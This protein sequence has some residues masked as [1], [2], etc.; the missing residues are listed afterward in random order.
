MLNCIAV[1][2]EPLALNLIEDFIRKTPFLHLQATCCNAIEAMQTLQHV[3]T[4]LLFLDIHMPTLNGMQLLK[5]IG[6]STMVILT[7]AYD[8]YAIEA[9]S[10][11]AVDYLLKPILFERFIKSVNKAYEL[12]KLRVLNP[13]A[14]TVIP[15]KK[16]D[17]MFIK[18][19]YRMLKV[20]YKDIL[21]IEGLK[22]YLKVFAGEKPILTLQSLKA[23]EDLLPS[24]DFIRVHRSYI[25]SLSKI[26]YIQKSRIGIGSKLI[27]VG[28]M[29]SEQFYKAIGQKHN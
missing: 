1:D 9:F 19:D 3:K 12:H 5:T 28:D 21:Y 8:N 14:A 2:D 15:E 4:D 17:F 6:K 16:E 26:E 29:Y 13:Q 24:K 20:N 27:P 11:D 18:S 23:F 10:L 22:D 7:T 25:V